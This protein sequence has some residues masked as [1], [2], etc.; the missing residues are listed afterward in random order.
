MMFIS[1]SDPAGL[2]RYKRLTGDRGAPSHQGLII[3]GKA[4]STGILKN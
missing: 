2:V 1:R 3:I 4:A